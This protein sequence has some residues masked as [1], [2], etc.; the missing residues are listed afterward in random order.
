LKKQH[1]NPDS[2]TH[3]NACGIHD[4]RHPD[5]R[6]RD[7]AE[8]DRKRAAMLAVALRFAR[9]VLPRLGQKNIILVM[10]F[11]LDCAEAGERYVDNQDIGDALGFTADEAKK[12]K[13]RGFERLKLEARKEG[14]V[15]DEELL[16][17]L[18]TDEQEDEHDEEA[19]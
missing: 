18:G 11:I 10:T 14:V 13:H 16:A 6:D 1:F 8:R 9:M 2:E 7:E 17:E 12:L 4:D 5:E 19:E 3:I 15:L